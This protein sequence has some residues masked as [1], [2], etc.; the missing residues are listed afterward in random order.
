MHKH[1]GGQLILEG[2]E[3]WD[4][5]FNTRL[6]TRSRETEFEE[7]MVTDGLSASLVVSRPKTATE[8]TVVKSDRQLS[9]ELLEGA[10]RVVAYEYSSRVSIKARFLR[11]LTIWSLIFL[12]IRAFTIF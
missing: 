10:N 8:E 4:Y 6:V 9:K 2:R 11:V 7:F 12:G 5:Y 3:P 1:L